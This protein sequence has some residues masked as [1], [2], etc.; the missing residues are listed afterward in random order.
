MRKFFERAMKE[1]KDFEMN[2]K[3]WMTDPSLTNGKEIID[4][5]SIDCYEKRLNDRLNHIH[6][7]IESH[8]DLL[9]R[10]TRK[11]DPER[12]KFFMQKTDKEKLG[13]LLQS[14]NLKYLNGV[15]A[16]GIRDDKNRFRIK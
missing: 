12:Y 15:V 6:E 9:L 5:A 2:G 13:V 7:A 1:K 8:L 14:E 3:A 4:T 10:V 11:K 16:K